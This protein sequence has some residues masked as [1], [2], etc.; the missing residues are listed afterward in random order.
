M[1]SFVKRGYTQG[2]PGVAV[3]RGKPRF[4]PA[5]VETPADPAGVGVKIFSGV[6]SPPGSG[7]KK[8]RGNNPAGVGVENIFGVITPPGSGL[9]FFTGVFTPPWSGSNFFSGF[10]PRR[11]RGEEMGPGSGLKR[12]LPR[13]PVFPKNPGQKPGFFKKRCFMFNLD[14]W[15]YSKDFCLIIYHDLFFIKMCQIHDAV[16]ILF[17]IC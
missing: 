2:L 15:N 16:L 8:K 6:K 13:Y 11:G 5:G 4:D 14:L 12:G 10:L 9:S 7:W 3:F 17:C 1:I